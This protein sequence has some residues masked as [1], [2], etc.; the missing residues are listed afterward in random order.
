MIDIVYKF[1]TVPRGRFALLSPLYINIQQEI[2]DNERYLNVPIYDDL[3]FK[4]NLNNFKNMNGGIIFNVQRIN[5]RFVANILALS[6]NSTKP[7]ILIGHPIE[8]E[9]GALS[10]T[11]LNS[12]FKIFVF[13]EI[14]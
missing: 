8:K 13:E 4:E 9:Y 12:I 2:K 1:H 3:L 10:I 5:P 7:I 11:P 6:K 14:E